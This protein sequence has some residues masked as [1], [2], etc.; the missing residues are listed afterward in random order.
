MYPPETPQDIQGPFW[1]VPEFL[2]TH[3]SPLRTPKDPQG[4]PGTFLRDL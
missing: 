3:A 1:R 2:G 4:P